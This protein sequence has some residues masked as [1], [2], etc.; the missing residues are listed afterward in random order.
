M[1]RE[2][3]YR[4]TVDTEQIRGAAVVMR[5]AFEQEMGRM[6]I[7][8]GAAGGSSVTQSVSRAVAGGKSGGGIL[9]SLRGMGG[10]GNLVAGGVAGYMGIA[11]AKQLLA[12]A[13]ELASYSTE[14]RRTSTAFELLSGSSDNAA[15]K[16]MAVQ[17]ASG[18]S[19]DK[20][21]A[22][23]ISNR[24]AALGMADTAKE[25]ERVTKFATISGRVL[26][27]DTTA[28]LDN[29]ALAASNLS[30]ARLDQL[31]LSSS[32]VRK[33]FQ[34]LR[35][36]MSDNKAFLEAMLVTGE[37]TFSSLNTGALLAASGQERFSKA[38]TESKE[39]LSF[40]GE[41]WD[42]FLL[43]VARDWM[44]DRTV[45][46][47]IARFQ[48]RIDEIRT[49]NPARQALSDPAFN[50]I[51]NIGLARA[52]I[53]GFKEAMTFGV[54]IGQIEKVIASFKGMS[55]A[56]LDG[57]PGIQANRDEMISLGEAAMLGPLS[58]E[59]L[60]RLKVLTEWWGRAAYQI[61]TAGANML[62][63]ASMPSV[64]SRVFDGT[65]FTSTGG[66]NWINRGPMVGP[67]EQPSG[68]TKPGTV[69]PTGAWSVDGIQDALADGA[70]ERKAL[71]KRAAEDAKNAWIS[72]GKD[73]AS[74][75]KSAI[76]GIPG[77]PGTGR[78]SVTQGDMDAAAAGASMR[79]ADSFIRE[80]QDELLNGVDRPNIDRDFI[81]KLTQTSGLSNEQLF[82]Q[83]DK[84][85]QSGQLFANPF[86]Q[87]NVDKIID[88]DAVGK[89]LQDQKDATTG[90]DFVEK[91]MAKRFGGMDFSSMG[92]TLAS[93]VS[94]VISDGTVDFA[95]AATSAIGG[96]FASKA[97]M[98]AFYDMGVDSSNMMWLGFSG[99]N[100]I[101]A[102]GYA[103]AFAA[104]IKDDI[105]AYIDARL[106]V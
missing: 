14:L 98:A 11:G 91:E 13:N 10:L 19:I 69:P 7:T 74:A 82:A 37:E 41:A 23:T 57:V 16:L 106:G 80:A 71:D 26:G 48:D 67:Q 88:F 73:T 12:G 39:R 4:V 95:G 83:L 68:W 32:M 21:S 99:D 87:E 9:D 29:M 78:S 96:Q 70:S 62:Q 103:A 86:A 49:A 79:Y 101:G 51:P 2:F 18:G 47:Q 72:A 35:G 24:A 22:M 77:L 63:V 105:K 20:L 33:R 84:Q 27:L 1:S 15:A 5:R 66:A 43:T 64:V 34:E 60:A 6:N 36:T 100:G 8:P 44:G 38:L 85:Y 53:M 59:Q 61:G 65:V 97:S 90:L 76:S 75:W 45:D 40:L 17:R 56:V 3:H 55:D 31:G 25:L 92:Q 89:G 54:E 58:D 46:E 30:F 104:V 52:D 50:D 94:D 28:A 102:N 93:G 42:K 81:E